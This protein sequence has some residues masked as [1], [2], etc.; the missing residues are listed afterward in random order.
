MSA[1]GLD[2]AP[3]L[4]RTSTEEFRSARAARRAREGVHIFVDNSNLTLAEIVREHPGKP[5]IDYPALL[6]LL[7]GPKG[8]SASAA[9]CRTMYLVGSEPA[10]AVARAATSS[11]H[12]AAVPPSRRAR[13]VEE[14]EAAGFECDIL[15]RLPRGGGEQAVDD[16]MHGR[17]L[18]ESHDRQRNPLPQRMIIVTGDGNLNAGGTNFVR[19]AELALQAGWSV[20]V[21]TWDKS[22]S[23][24]WRELAAAAQA[25][26]GGGGGGTIQLRSFDPFFAQIVTVAAQPVVGAAPPPTLPPQHP[27]AAAAAGGG[28]CTR[29]AAVGSA[30]APAAAFEK[31]P[32]RGSTARL[33]ASAMAGT[34][35]SGLGA[36]TRS[37]QAREQAQ[38]QV[39]SSTRQAVMHEQPAM[40]PPPGLGWGAPAQAQAPPQPQTSYQPPPRTKLPKGA[41]KL[42]LDIE[43]MRMGGGE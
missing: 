27:A 36:R 21:W 19:C 16:K 17:M 43:C 28:V 3:G 15:K 4:E 7:C 20:D 22:R 32:V 18:Q 37:Q 25:D 40:L 8:C 33:E 29:R 39:V 10:A 41:Q 26:G 31:H 14:A 42:W 24:K 38:A 30:A 9:Q 35:P 5:R 11:R 23:K 2:R 34:G 1:G 6:R 12:Q 13:W